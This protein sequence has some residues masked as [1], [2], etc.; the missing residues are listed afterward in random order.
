M[1]ASDARYNDRKGKLQRS[2][3]KHLDRGEHAL[4]PVVMTLLGQFLSGMFYRVCRPLLFTI[5]ITPM[6]DIW[7]GSLAPV[8][9]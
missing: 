9:N 4:E 8:L 6:Q 1:V 3:T 2:R 5:S 7:I